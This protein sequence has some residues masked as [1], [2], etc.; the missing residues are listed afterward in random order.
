[1][2]TIDQQL[3][4]NKLYQ[5]EISLQLSDLED[6]PDEYMSDSIAAKY[7]HLQERLRRLQDWHG[8]MTDLTNLHKP[9]TD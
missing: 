7:V 6:I 4:E 5:E 3:I 8:T 1:M 9:L 2:D